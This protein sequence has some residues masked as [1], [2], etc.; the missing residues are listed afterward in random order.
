M[1]FEAK[2]LGGLEVDDELELGGLQ[3]RQVGWL[4]AFENP[5]GIKTYLTVG[6]GDAGAVTHQA[7]RVSEFPQAVARRKSMP[8]GQCNDLLLVRNQEPAG[9]DEQCASATLNQCCEG[10]LDIA[11]HPH[12]G[13]DELL[14]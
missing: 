8:R 6:I 5:A 10:R 1:D 13:N 7:A 14:A 12:I 2:H 4:L 11:I 9:A 3:D